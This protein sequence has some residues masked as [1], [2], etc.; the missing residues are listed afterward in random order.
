MTPLTQPLQLSAS[1]FC[2]RK[3]V[4]TRL[5]IAAAAAL[6]AM[7]ILLTAAPALAQSAAKDRASNLLA[8]GNKLLQKGEHAAALAKYEA[9]Y[10]SYPSPSLLLN[11]G[12]TLRVL[13]RHAEAANTYAK[14]MRVKHAPKRVPEVEEALSELDKK[15]ARLTIEVSTRDATVKLN[16]RTLDR[17]ERQTIIRVDP[18]PHSITAT[19]PGYEDASEDIRVTAGSQKTI[20]LKLVSLNDEEDD[21]NDMSSMNNAAPMSDEPNANNNNNNNK[22]RV[23]KIAGISAAGIGLLSVAA[24]VKFGLDAKSFSDELSDQ[25]G[26]W[27]Q[28]QLD[29]QSKGDSAQTKT[30]IFAAVGGAA[31][32]TGGVFYALGWRLSRSNDVEEEE[33]EE[34][35]EGIA[36]QAITPIITPNTLGWAL[37]GQF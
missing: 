8:Q 14:W 10:D 12:T 19:K 17:D 23:L 30:F 37:S 18:G 4:A 15:V 33:E 3:A 7:V 22:A 28:E 21:T 29:K 32:V 11:I 16:G 25:N 9:A 35:D 5:T 1:P 36:L 24:S 26:Q 13:G 20:A 31:I 6:A 34:E 27:T 2:L